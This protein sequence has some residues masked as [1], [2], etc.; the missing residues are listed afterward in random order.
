VLKYYIA[1]PT[2]TQPHDALENMHIIVHRIVDWLYLTYF[3]KLFQAKEENFLL[4][5]FNL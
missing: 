1:A 4:C 2:C 3:P 5:S